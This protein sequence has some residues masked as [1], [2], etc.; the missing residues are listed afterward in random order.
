MP[1]AA[2]LEHAGSQLHRLAASSNSSFKHLLERA[3]RVAPTPYPVLLEGE[4]GT[5]KELL[6]HWI[7]AHSGR[8]GSFVPVNCS[9]IPEPLFEAELFGARRGAY[10]GLQVDHPGLFR[11]AVRGTL[12]LDEIGELPAP[13]QAKLLRVLQ[14]GEIRSLGS[15]ERVRVDVRILAATHKNLR[16]L[17][18]ANLFRADLFF[19]ISAAHMLLP[20][21]RQRPED[22]PRL[23]REA[24]EEAARAAGLPVPQV[25]PSLFEAALHYPWPGNIRELRQSVAAAVLCTASSTLAA[26][27][28]ALPEHR[29]HRPAPALDHSA[30][31]SLFEVLW[32]CE[33]SYLDDLLRRSEGNLSRAARTAG[34][35]RTSL[36]AKLVQHGLRPCERAAPRRSRL[37]GPPAGDPSP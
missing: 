20:P 26:R 11:A 27:D 25:D 12:F 6:A 28:L 29:L 9:A 34:L 22:I 31:R 19:R 13:L 4:T 21:L 5:G 10:T 18:D 2:A 33:R 3:R 37:R 14:D 8:S 17:V 1:A 15:T 24:V 32:D 7:H 16:T 30:E 35:S 23:I 36:R